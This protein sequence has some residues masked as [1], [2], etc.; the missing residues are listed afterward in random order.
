MT[1]AL[2]RQTS[3][4]RL[5]AFALALTAAC[6]SAIGKAPPSE[7]PAF[8][9]IVVVPGA[10]I[11]TAAKAAR[12]LQDNG[13]AT[14]RFRS[15][16]TWGSRASDNMNARLRY[17]SPSSD[18][19][20]ILVELWGKCERGGRNCFVGELVRLVGALTTEEAPPQ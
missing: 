12:A 11:V 20:R 1:L 16:S 8:T 13:Y 2:S 9:R 7:E 19:T 6:A 15:D 10:P 17:T 18:S 14:R 3:L 4:R 5:S